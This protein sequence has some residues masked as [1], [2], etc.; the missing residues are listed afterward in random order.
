MFPI[1]RTLSGLLTVALL[2][3]LPLKAQLNPKWQT[4]SSPDFLNLYQ[5]STHYTVKPE[6]V[7]VLDFSGSM[8]ALMYHKNYNNTDKNDDD[9]SDRG[10]WMKFTISGD[11]YSTYDVAASIS[12]LIVGG[13]SFNLRNGKLVRPDGTV[14]TADLLNSNY[15]WQKLSGEPDTDYTKNR[16]DSWTWP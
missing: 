15:K 13:Y 16:R 4:S 6:I 12:G 2:A 1:L 11:D 7:T 3:A 8:S 14:L 9:P 5:Q 10:A